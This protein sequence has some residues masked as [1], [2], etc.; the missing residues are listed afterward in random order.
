MSRE[1]HDPCIEDPSIDTIIRPAVSN[2]DNI[3]VNVRQR[4]K[5]LASVELPCEKVVKYCL[6]GFLVKRLALL[7]LYLVQV[8]RSPPVMNDLDPLWDPLEI[9]IQ[10]G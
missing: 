4:L 10:V 6:R 8:L 2:T 5:G 7:I 1:K 9:P 3:G